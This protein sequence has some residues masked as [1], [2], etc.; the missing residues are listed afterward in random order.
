MIFLV[1][2]EGV[3]DE[4][5]EL[6]TSLNPASAAL[7]AERFSSSDIDIDKSL[8]G[9]LKACI[10]A[11]SA[12]VNRAHLIGY[13]SN[14]ALIRE[15]FTREGAGSLISDDSLDTLR[16]ATIDDVSAILS[17]IRP[18]EAD[19]TLVERSRERLETEIENFK[20]IE[21]EGAIIAC[22]A[23]YRTSESLAEIACIA[24]HPNYRRGGLGARLLQS[25]SAEAKRLGIEKVFVLTTVTAHWFIDHGF[26]QGTLDDLPEQ[27]Q[28]LYNLQ[29]KSKI[30]LKSV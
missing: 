13:R 27:R 28:A 16:Q 9:A 8:G 26:A 1:P 10:K 29:R 20:V 25:L 12:G 22:A 23:L 17:L 11:N 6:I 3:C 7:A 30:F 14:G 15:L 24:T 18:L 19:G 5:G 2:Q 21:L 4:Q